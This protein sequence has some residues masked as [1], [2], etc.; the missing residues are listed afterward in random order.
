M[1][2]PLNLAENH[3]IYTVQNNIREIFQ[4]KL[5]SYGVTYFE[6]LR[7][8]DNGDCIILASN[9]EVVRYLFNNEVP[10]IA[11][12]EQEF[13]KEIFHYFVL[14]VGNYEK[15]L[16][17]LKSYFNLAHFIDFVERHNGYIDLYCFGADAN[18]PEIVNFYLNNI[19]LLENFKCYF[20]DKSRVLINQALKEKVLLSNAMLPSYKGLSCGEQTLATETYALSKR[21]TDCLEYLLKGM[22][23]KQIAKQL[24]LSPRTVEHYLKAIKVKYNVQSRADL[25]KI[26]MSLGIKARH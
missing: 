12:I 2:S 22:T 19:D 3:Y 7:L 11:T 18:N 23:L 5:S 15:A 4:D 6:Y 24:S 8:Y 9:Q 13:I 16:H 26:A 20:K 25:F 17:E 14:P 10:L 21:Q 1:R